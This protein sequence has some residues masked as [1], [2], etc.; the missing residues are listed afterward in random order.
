[1]LIFCGRISFWG[2]IFVHFVFNNTEKENYYVFSLRIFT[3]NFCFL[4]M[5]LLLLIRNIIIGTSIYI[6]LT[7]VILFLRAF[8]NF[9]LISQLWVFAVSIKGSSFI[10]VNVKVYFLSEFSIFQYKF[11]RPSEMNFLKLKRFN[12][13]IFC[14]LIVVIVERLH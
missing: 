5:T 14:V 11:I 13:L 8:F 6:C 3:F 2:L 7:F 1:M 12:P 4:A 9:F 10:V